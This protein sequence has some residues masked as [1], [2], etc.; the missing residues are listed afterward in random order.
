VY[1]SH[2][3]RI[4]ALTSAPKE[5]QATCSINLQIQAFNPWLRYH[6]HFF[7]PIDSISESTCQGRH[8]R[9]PRFFIDESYADQFEA[10]PL[11]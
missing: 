9:K 8:G 10:A 1:V 4:E 3:V 7:Q 6:L 2:A 5:V 11:Y